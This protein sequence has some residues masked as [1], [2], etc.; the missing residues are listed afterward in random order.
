MH[1]VCLKTMKQI[2]VSPCVLVTANRI[3]ERRKVSLLVEWRQPAFS[4][5]LAKDAG[6]LVWTQRNVYTWANKGW[7]SWWQLWEQWFIARAAAAAAERE[8]PWRQQEAGP[9][10]QLPIPNHSPS[11]RIINAAIHSSTHTRLFYTPLHAGKDTLT[12][13]CNKGPCCGRFW[14]VICLHE[15]FPRSLSPSGSMPHEG[16]LYPRW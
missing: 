12:Q 10:E 15:F 14:S 6:L 7:R 9:P 13:K 16:R 1:N 8:E 2:P 3:L 5:C 11:P 4:R